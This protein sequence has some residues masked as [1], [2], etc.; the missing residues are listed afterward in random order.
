MTKKKNPGEKLPQ[1]QPTLYRAE[2]DAQL[3]DHMS[4]GLSFESFAGVIGVSRSVI[5]DW[6]HAQATFLDAKMKGEQK[7]LLFYERIGIQGMAGKL[8]S[9]NATTYVWMTKNMCNWR[10]R[11]Q[12]DVTSNGNTIQLAYNLEDK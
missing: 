8:P 6:T 1:G 9:F 10:D 7:R 5:Y 12:T 11:I 3:I 4:K 2:Y